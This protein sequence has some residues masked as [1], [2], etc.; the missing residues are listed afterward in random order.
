MKKNNRNENI[1]SPSLNN[2]LQKEIN[3][4]RTRVEL[5]LQ[6]LIRGAEANQVHQQVTDLRIYTRTAAKETCESNDADD[7]LLLLSSSS[8]NNLDSAPPIIDLTQPTTT[9]IQI[10]DEV[11]PPQTVLEVINNEATC[12]VEKESILDPYGDKGIYTGELLVNLKKPHGLGTMI[13]DDGRIFT[14]SWNNGKWHGSGIASFANGDKFDGTYDLDRRHGFG[15]YSW[16]DGRVYEGE[17]YHDQRQGAGEYRWPDGSIYRGEF[18]T[19]HRHGEGTYTYSDGSSYTG[20]WSKG[21]YHG[22]GQCVWN[23]GR[24]YKG[25]WKEGKADGYGV[26]KRCDGSIRHEGMWNQDV[27]IREQQRQH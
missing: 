6:S 2:E 9:K 16:K 18:A 26:E 1:A 22:V 25:E 4:M 27:P 20:E 12:Y 13:Y 5:Q 8:G 11:L 21:C 14:G 15:V 7:A 17:F 10:N 3:E 19:G 24:T 23:D